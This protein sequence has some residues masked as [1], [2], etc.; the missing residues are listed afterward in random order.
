VP[1]STSG[2]DDDYPLAGVQMRFSELVEAFLLVRLF[3]LKNQR[4]RG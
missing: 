2:T 4:A 3:D 1:N